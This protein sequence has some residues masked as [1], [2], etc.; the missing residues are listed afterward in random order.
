MLIIAS[1]AVAGLGNETVNVPAVAV[2][3]PS[4]SNATHNLS[5]LSS[6]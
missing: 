5:D 2:L 4:K 6:L 3:F 1:A